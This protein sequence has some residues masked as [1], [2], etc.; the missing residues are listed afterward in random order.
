VTIFGLGMFLG[1]VYSPAPL[2]WPHVR[3][4]HPGPDNSHVT[5][6]FPVPA[7][8]AE[9]CCW[10]PGATWIDAGLTLTDTDGTSVTVEFPVVDPLATAVAVTVTVGGEGTFA[11]AV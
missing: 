7:T 10:A 5:T 8:V 11:G 2:I 1:A 4:E 3:P 6:W 9:N